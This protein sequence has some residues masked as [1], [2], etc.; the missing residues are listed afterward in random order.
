MNDVVNPVRLPL[1]ALRP[2][3]RRAR[4]IAAYTQGT[5]GLEGQGLD[6]ATYRQMARELFASLV[7]QHAAGAGPSRRVPE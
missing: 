5:M 4:F 7:A 1:S 6:P 2:L 3:A